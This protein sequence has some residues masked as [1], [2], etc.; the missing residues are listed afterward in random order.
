MI[1][2]QLLIFLAVGCLTVIIDYAVYR[3]LAVFLDLGINIGKG[4]SFFA[5]TVFAYIANRFWTFNNKDP[6][7]GSIY[8]FIPLYVSTCAINIVVNAVVLSFFSNLLFSGYLAFIIATFCSS[9][10][11]FLG[12]KFFVFRAT[13]VK[14]SL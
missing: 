7:V 1:R 14:R 2:R 13:I 5:G 8:R 10:L 9:V 6:D 11:N 12:M 4:L 3:Y